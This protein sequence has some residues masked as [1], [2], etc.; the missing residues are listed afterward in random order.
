LAT[1]FEV[2]GLE[3]AFKA[4]GAGFL[5]ATFTTFLGNSFEGFAATFATTLGAAFFGAAFLT[6]AAGLEDFPEDFRVGEGLD[7]FFNGSRVKPESRA[8]KDRST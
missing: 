7:V 5:A 6:E 2:T 4:L 3:E 8:R 1:G